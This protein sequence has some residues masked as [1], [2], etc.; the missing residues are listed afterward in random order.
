[1]NKTV[2]DEERR[3]SPLLSRRFYAPEQPPQQGI[4]SLVSYEGEWVKKESRGIGFDID[5]MSALRDE[6][7]FPEFEVVDSMTIKV[8]KVR[9]YNK[10]PEDIL[11][12]KTGPLQNHELDIKTQ[13][14]RIAILDTV[15]RLWNDTHSGNIGI[16]DQDRLVII[17]AGF[18]HLPE[19]DDWDWLLVDLYH[20]CRNLE[21]AKNIE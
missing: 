17:D 10:H 9:I 7:L 4:E 18:L 5:A 19:M 14:L 11:D 20:K 1:M 12:Y 13:L 3:V 15:G 6:G 21:Y 16:D 8:R 2:L